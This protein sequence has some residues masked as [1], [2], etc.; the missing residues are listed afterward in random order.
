MSTTTNPAIRCIEVVEMI[1]E[2]L[3]RT[4]TAAETARLEEHLSGCD[5]CEAYVK[6]MRATIS[7]LHG[8]AGP[9]GRPAGYDEILA[10]YKARGV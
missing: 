5:A 4:L 8:L 3:E 9:S 10:A 7:G 1:S 6:Q 2:Y